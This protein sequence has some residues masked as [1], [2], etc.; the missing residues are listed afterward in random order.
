MVPAHE[1]KMDGALFALMS[2]QAESHAQ[3]STKLVRT[4]FA[5]AHRKLTMSRG[6]ISCG[7]PINFYAIGWIDQHH[8]RLL[9]AEQSLERGIKQGVT[10]EHPMISKLPKVARSGDGRARRNHRNLFSRIR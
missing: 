2:K 10:A 6:A 5:A 9:T 7:M 8:V 1:R 3:E 4:H